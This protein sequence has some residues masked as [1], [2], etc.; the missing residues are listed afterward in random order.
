MNIGIRLSVRHHSPFDSLEGL[1]TVK[2]LP[3]PCDC[4]EQGPATLIGP[5]D[6][7]VLGHPIISLSSLPGFHLSASKVFWGPGAWQHIR[8]LTIVYGSMAAGKTYGPR[9]LRV[10]SQDLEQKRE[11][12]RLLI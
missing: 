7:A 1:R 6:V 12:A 11:R 8:D 9:T 3:L 2:P 5:A 10:A 4:S